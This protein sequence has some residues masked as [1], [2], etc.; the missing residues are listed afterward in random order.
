MHLESY[1][2]V[3]PCISVDLLEK[4]DVR[5]GTIL[6]VSDVPGSTKLVELR[7]GFG[8]HERT[9][10]VGMKKERSNP[11]EV[12]GKQAL[13]IVNLEPRPMAGRVSQG[14]LFDIGHADG[15]AAVLAMPE[16]P[17]PDGARAG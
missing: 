3:K 13:F 1:A 16:A 9:I 12:E 15:L 2:P 5:A 10:L 17:V 7:V 11:R 6:A 14:M 8:D 4:L